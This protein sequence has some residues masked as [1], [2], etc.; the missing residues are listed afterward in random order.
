MKLRGAL[1]PAT[2][3]VEVWGWLR[4]SLRKLTE[5]WPPEERA[6]GAQCGGGGSRGVW[7]GAGQRGCGGQWAGDT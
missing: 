3:G 5:A 6:W 7:R 1:S 4:S 2:A